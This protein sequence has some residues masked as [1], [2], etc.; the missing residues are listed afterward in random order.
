[1][2]ADMLFEIGVEEIPAGVVLP[3]LQ[4]LEEKIGSALDQARLAHGPISTF[5]TPRRLAVL[6]ADVALRQPDVELE[7]KGPPAAAA[8]DGDGNPT[9]AAHGFA[10]SRGVAVSDLQVRDTDG[11][12][13]VFATVTEA[14][15]DSIEVLPA[16]LAE[17]TSSLSFPKTMRWG[18]GDFRFARPIRWIVALLGEQVIPVEIAGIQAGRTTYGHRTLSAGPIALTAPADYLGALEQAG[19]IADHRRRKQL[20][21]EQATGAAAQAGGR[22]RLDPEL[23]EE[24]NFMVEYPT[25]LVG[26]FDDRFLKL[27]EQV[28]VTVM[29][30]HQRYFPV[31][32][33]HGR[34]LPMFVAIRN[35]DDKG[36]DIV[37]A[38]NEKVIVPRLADAEFYLSEDLRRPLADRI[39]DL[40]RVTYLE[41]MGTLAD[42]SARLEALA[43]WLCVALSAS[44]AEQETTRRAAR[45][46]KCDL[47][48]NMIGDTKLAKLQ[49]LIG[50][51]YAR[52]SQEPEAVA[53]AIAE[54]YQPEGADDSPPQTNPGRALALADKMDHLAACFRL[55]LRP[56]GSA[57]PH[58][59]RRAALGIVRIIIAARARV[60]LPAFIDAALKL[61]PEVEGPNVVPT[62]EAAAQIADFIKQRLQAELSARGVA[63]DLVRAVLAA[64]CPDLLDAYDRALAL[65]QIREQEEDFDAVIIAAERSANIVRP[66]RA[67]LELR[68]RPEA[69]DA[70]EAVALH[71]ACVHTQR[72]MEA[73]L[74][75]EG[76][77][78]YRAAWRALA[79]LREPI[80]AFFDAVLVMAED[81]EVRN[82]RLALVAEVDDL[83]LRLLDVKEIVIAGQ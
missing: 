54:H 43:P 35:G 41:G 36:L 25:A 17:A 5:A 79:A 32:D 29:S 49:G 61:L 15:R 10:Q 37:R 40:A 55:G 77:R 50:A 68:L 72:T 48:T 28:I 70:P 74:A 20:I 66:V 81:E 59:L 78:D 46:A 14:G 67:Q 62:E 44:E 19:V 64:P 1:M 45:L 8:F 47:T 76:E 23:V 51:E 83:F 58:A 12:R 75:P 4:Q 22:V 38:G 30:A 2:T 7:I 57:D 60:D 18:E 82:N 63:Y 9:K 39:P 56:T 73:A 42:K 69:L 24:V 13:Y 71:E 6:V 16:L 27:P 53:A 65:Q 3:A 26:R 21:I 31:E 11:G 52:R 33:V 34:L 80:D